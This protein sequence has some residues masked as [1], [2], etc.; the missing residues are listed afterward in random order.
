[1]V[2]YLDKEPAPGG[3]LSC[4]HATRSANVEDQQRELGI[5]AQILR[6]LGVGKLRLLSNSAR[7]I[8]GLEGFGLH[9]VDRVSIGTGKRAKRAG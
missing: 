7:R 6:D 9:V 2:V 1:V 5:G 3:K 4:T 8:A